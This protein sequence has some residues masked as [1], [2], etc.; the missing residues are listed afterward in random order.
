MNRIDVIPSEHGKWKVLHNFIQHGINYNT[1]EQA[2]KEA[3][4]MKEKFY[5]TARKV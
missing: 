3:Q 4:T 2:D 1:K 5:P